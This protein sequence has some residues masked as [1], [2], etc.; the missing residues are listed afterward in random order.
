LVEGSVIREKP[1]GR[2]DTKN[3]AQRGEDSL[4]LR[5]RAIFKPVGEAHAVRPPRGSFDLPILPNEKII[6]GVGG[7][8]NSGRGAAAAWLTWTLVALRA[9]TLVMEEAMQAILMSGGWRL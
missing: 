3:A 7:G 4:P 9:T 1:R 2:D 6:A 8:K 5:T